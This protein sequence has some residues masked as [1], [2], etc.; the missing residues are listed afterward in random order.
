MSVR[1]RLCDV[2]K[3][4]FGRSWFSPSFDGPRLGETVH[5]SNISGWERLGDS[6]PHPYLTGGS[7]DVTRQTCK[8]SCSFV[9]ASAFT[10]GNWQHYLGSLYAHSGE[11]SANLPSVVPINEVAAAGVKGYKR[12]K[13]TARNG[14]LAQAIIELRDI[15]RMLESSNFT[16][17]ARDRTRSIAKKAGNQYLNTVFGWLPLLKDVQDLVRNSINQ[18]KKFDQLTRDNG[19]VVRRSG[20]VSLLQSTATRIQTGG[21]YT[22]PSLNSNLYVG[23]Q[24]EHKTEREYQRFWFSGAFQYNIE[25]PAVGRLEKHMDI[26]KMDQILYGTDIS[27]SL[28]WELVPWSWLEDWF[29][30]SGD[31]MANFFEDKSD[32]LVA[33]YAYSMGHKKTETEYIVSGVMKGSGPFSCS[34]T[35]ITESKRRISADPYGF[36]ISPPAM[37]NNQLAILA[38]LG[39]SRWG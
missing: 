18:Q 8:T 21:F 19:Q 13:P 10:F 37:S 24:T 36:W 27:P 25:Q 12:F 29:S 32:N 3:G 4:E 20:Q 22:S 26:R 7:F 34:Q 16:R 38:S 39:L 28:A 35:Y 30:S 2:D 11:F 1:T 31:A 6:S 15:P 33:P 9:H 5:T 23:T 14:S 17:E